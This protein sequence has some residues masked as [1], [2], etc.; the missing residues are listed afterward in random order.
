MSPA[1]ARD[2]GP[3]QRQK[4]ERRIKDE[5]FAEKFQDFERMKSD[6]F[7][8]TPARPQ[9][10]ERDP[11]VLSVPGDRRNSA[12]R[13]RAEKPIQSVRFEFA[14]QPWRNRQDKQD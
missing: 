5:M 11:G 10:R 12:N 3:G 6:F 14:P 13:E 2:H 7:I 1:P 8:Q 4:K 9:M